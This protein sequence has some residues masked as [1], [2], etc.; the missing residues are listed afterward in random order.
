MSFLSARSSKPDAPEKQNKR[1]ASLLYRG[2]TPR[3][4][5]TYRW[6]NDEPQR[7]QDYY[8]D[9]PSGAIP[10]R[11]GAKPALEDPN[12]PSWIRNLASEPEVLPRAERSTKPSNR[13]PL[14]GEQTNKSGEEDRIAPFGD[15]TVEETRGMQRQA[16]QV[17]KTGQQQEGDFVSDSLD[18]AESVARGVMGPSFEPVRDFVK[19]TAELLDPRQD[20]EAIKDGG[21]RF[22]EAMKEGDLS[23]MAVGAAEQLTGAAGL[24]LGPLVDASVGITQAAIPLIVPKASLTKKKP[25]T[26]CWRFSKTARHHP[27]GMLVYSRSAPTPQPVLYRMAMNTF[28]GG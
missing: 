11:K 1:R 24:F 8:A 12:A 27:K 16:E 5:G 23:G 2:T 10:T 6:L 25:K 17:R 15:L 21:R 26:K 4:G 20:H 13:K 7:V 19:G 22:N 28:H 18:A 9:K 14:I 3:W